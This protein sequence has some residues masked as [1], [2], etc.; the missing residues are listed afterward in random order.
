MI[1]IDLQNS[2]IDR[3]INFDGLS[4]VYLDGGVVNGN[5]EAFSRIYIRSAIFDN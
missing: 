1:T 3:V 5:K 4:S 2:K